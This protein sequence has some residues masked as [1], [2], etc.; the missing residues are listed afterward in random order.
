MAAMPYQP[1]TWIVDATVI[2]YLGV[3]AGGEASRRSSS[4]A[5]EATETGDSPPPRPHSRRG[6]LQALFAIKRF[7]LQLQC[8]GEEVT[9]QL[10]KPHTKNGCHAHGEVVQQPPPLASPRLAATARSDTQTQTAP[11]L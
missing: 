6:W 8:F 5:A 7:L 4:A 10:C 9:T 3:R 2:G 11:E 1:M